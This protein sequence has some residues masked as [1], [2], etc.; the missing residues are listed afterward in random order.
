MELCNRLTIHIKIKLC[1]VQ[2]FIYS[3][4]TTFQTS[5]IDDPEIGSLDRFPN[6]SNII[7]KVC[8]TES[9]NKEHDFL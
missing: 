9:E 6:V 1:H 4:K 5:P 2:Y 3:H 7:K 8:I